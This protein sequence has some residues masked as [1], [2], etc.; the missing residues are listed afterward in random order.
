ML[1]YPD[2]RSRPGSWRVA[3][4]GLWLAAGPL[5]AQGLPVGQPETLG[6]SPERLQRIDALIA[7][8]IEEVE[9][10]GAVA[11]IARRGRVAFLES[12]GMADVDDGEPM[13]TD[14]IFRIA[15]MTKPITSLAVMMLY[16][17]GHFFLSDPVSDF[18]PEFGAPRVLDLSLIHI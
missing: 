17:E 4:A 8:A 11:L 9:I 18:I 16:E 12:Y 13:R 3:W 14:T 6:F 10:A 1:R 15:S 7:E 2:I 5:F